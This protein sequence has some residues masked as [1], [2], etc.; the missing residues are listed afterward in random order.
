MRRMCMWR[1]AMCMP[2][3]VCGYLV[4]EAFSS[5]VAPSIL[6][7]L[8]YGMHTCR[9]CGV[10][11]VSWPPVSFHLW[12]EAADCHVCQACVA[13]RPPLL[14][15]DRYSRRCGV[16]TTL[17]LASIV[18]FE[19]KRPPDGVSY[20][21]REALGLQFPAGSVPCSFNVTRARG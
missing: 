18:I 11:R 8:V 4:V 13:R 10:F 17:L 9:S 5:S 7:K 16:M 20:S 14:S 2:R 15:T 19:P 12:S 6:R 1:S 3:V 21:A